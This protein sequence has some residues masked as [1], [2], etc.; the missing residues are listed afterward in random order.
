MSSPTYLIDTHLLYWCMTGSPFS[1]TT[2]ST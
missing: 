2:M 1:S